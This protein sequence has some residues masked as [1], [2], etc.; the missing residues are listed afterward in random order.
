MWEKER[1]KENT[2][3]G[4]ERK[5][6]N[7]GITVWV[8]RVTLPPVSVVRVPVHL[9]K[10]T[11]LNSLR[12]LYPLELLRHTRSG[13][14]CT[15]INIDGVHLLNTISGQTLKDPGKTQVTDTFPPPLLDFALSVVI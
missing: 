14:L 5:E 9:S 11:S 15:N 10:W 6:R 12:F 3:L 13:W 8:T 4:R 1:D 2:K 7:Q